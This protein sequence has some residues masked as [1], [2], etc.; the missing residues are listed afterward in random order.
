M[1]HHGCLTEP[2]SDRVRP[3]EFSR[4]RAS[5][6]ASPTPGPSASHRWNHFS[7]ESGRHRFC[8]ET[9]KASC[10][11]ASLSAG[12]VLRSRDRAMETVPPRG[13]RRGRPRARVG[14]CRKW[15]HIEMARPVTI[16]GSPWE[17]VRRGEWTSLAT[18]TIVWLSK[19]H[20]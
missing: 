12:D 6:P 15:C 2:L 7:S 4:P 16:T 19:R 10:A 17:D 20:S 18:V 14:K 9:G 13:E 5:E 3:G 8:A 1:N 11:S